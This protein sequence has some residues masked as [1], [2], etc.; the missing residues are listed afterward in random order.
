MAKFLCIVVDV[1][2][3]KDV[4]EYTLSARDKLEAEIQAKNI[5]KIESHYTPRL[6]PV[7]DCHFDLCCI[8][9]NS[10]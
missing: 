6:P 10:P 9:E 1:I 3:K 4:K 8:E 7:E 5:Y 2:N